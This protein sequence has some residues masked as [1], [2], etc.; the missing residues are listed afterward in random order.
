MTRSRIQS[1]LAALCLAGFVSPCMAKQGLDNRLDQAGALYE[2]RHYAEAYRTYLEL[3][4][5]GVAFAQYRVSYMN[6][7]GHGTP[8]DPVESLAWAVLAAEK[9]Q[10]DLSSY[11]DAVAALVPSEQRKKAQKKADYYLRRWGKEDSRQRTETLARS[12]EGGCTGSR[13]A[14]NCGLSVT[15]SRTW[16]SWG[17]DRSADPQHKERIEQLNRSI[18]S[19]A[20]NF[21]FGGF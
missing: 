7:M 4:K 13:L 21:S 3:A 8:A 2:N 15:T 12:S 20:G 10:T 9:A 6:A 17:S 19:Q 18:L 1:T 14:A 5:D 16:I 11:Q